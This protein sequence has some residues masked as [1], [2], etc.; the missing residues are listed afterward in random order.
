INVQAGQSGYIQQIDAEQIGIAA[1]MLGAGRAKKEDPIDY[2]V[3]ITLNKKIGDSVQAGDS[4]CTLHANRQNTR[5]VEE[6]VR[7][8]YRISTEQPA[9]VRLIYDVID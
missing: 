3:G 7:S 9:P 6:L 2:A 5:D 1:M 4:V 8:A